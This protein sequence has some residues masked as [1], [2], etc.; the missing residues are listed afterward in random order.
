MQIDLSS[1]RSIFFFRLL[2][3]VN[4]VL[5]VNFCFLTS[6]D[7]NVGLHTLQEL[8]NVHLGVR[9]VDACVHKVGHRHVQTIKKERD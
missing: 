2:F 4:D 6:E 5:T 9:V 8:L 7:I 3:N 1:R